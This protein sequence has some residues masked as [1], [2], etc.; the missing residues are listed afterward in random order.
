MNKGERHGAPWSAADLA[1]LELMVSQQ[2]ALSEIAAQV[3]RTERAIQAR[4]WKLE[5]Q[6][7]RGPRSARNQRRHN[8]ASFFLS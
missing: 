3:G 8:G 7:N 4:L 2:T 6:R 5:R 1:Q